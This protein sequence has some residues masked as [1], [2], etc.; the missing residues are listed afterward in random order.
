ML[1]FQI[2]LSFKTLHNK[3]WTV[4]FSRAQ[5]WSSI[6]WKKKEESYLH[7]MTLQAATC[8]SLS[9]VIVKTQV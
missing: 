3:S 8:F 4:T 7:Y 9:Y 1:Y 5:V 2:I 6:F